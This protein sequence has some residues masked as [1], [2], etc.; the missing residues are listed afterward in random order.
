MKA[1]TIRNFVFICVAALSSVF[2]G[3]GTL[4]DPLSNEIIS[5]TSA[6]GPASSA[7]E[8]VAANNNWEKIITSESYTGKIAFKFK[9]ETA[10]RLRNDS[11]G[12][13]PLSKNLTRSRNVEFISSTGRNLSRVTQLIRENASA[14][15]SRAIPNISEEAL[16]ELKE[17]FAEKGVYYPDWNLTYIISDNDRNSALEIYRQ[18][19]KDDSIEW[20]EPIRKKYLAGVIQTAD[21]S[22]EQNYLKPFSSHSGV[23]ALAGWAAGAFGQ[24]VTIGDYELGWN[25]DHEDI[26]IDIDDVITNMQPGMTQAEIDHGT[27]VIGVVA[28]LHNSIGIN[29][30]APQSNIKLLDA[31]SAGLDFGG[32]WTDESGKTV[33]IQPGDILMIEVQIPGTINT[34]CGGTVEAQLGCLPVESSTYEFNHISSLLAAGYIIIEGAGNGSVDLSQHLD[35]STEAIMVGASLGGTRQKAPWSNC[36]PRVDL[37]AWGNNVVTTGYGDK[38]PS[39]TDP[40]KKYTSVFSGTSSATAIVGGVAAQIQSYVK[41]MLSSAGAAGVDRFY[42]DNS[43][44][45]ELLFASG[46][47]AVYG[48]PQDPNPNCNIGKQPDVAAAIALLEN[49]FIEEFN[50]NSKTAS[51]TQYAAA[52]DIDGDGRSDVVGLDKNFV[53]RIDLSSVASDAPDS[54][55]G[56]GE[57]D[58]TLDFSEYTP[59]GGMYFP[60]V[61]DINSDGFA[62]L[63]IY[64]SIS[65][66]LYIHYT[67]RDMFDN[68]VDHAGGG[69]SRI[70]DY[71][72]DPNWQPY[73]RPMLGNVNVQFVSADGAYQLDLND[74]ED[75]VTIDGNGRLSFS[76]MLGDLDS[77]GLLDEEQLQ[78]APGWAY[79]NVGG[80]YL[81]LK[82]PDS[83]PNPAQTTM[84]KN[85]VSW[86][87]YKSTTLFCTELA[88]LGHDCANDVIYTMINGSFGFKLPTGEYY[89][90]T[91]SITPESS[92]PQPIEGFGGIDCRPI[93]ADY[94]G[95][96]FVDRATY[97]GDSFRVAF[98]ND[99]KLYVAN[100]PD[101]FGSIPAHIYQGGVKYSDIVAIYNALPNKLKPGCEA[102]ANCSIFDAPPPIGPRFAECLK[103]W[104]R[105]PQNCWNE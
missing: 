78:I 25:F 20:V 15:V 56:F 83:S 77:H 12:E 49:G 52:Y 46:S 57:N 60:V 73:M 6:D 8:E 81:K 64:D 90:Y 74:G 98:E 101:S 95:D 2:A 11:G 91:A 38:D 87:Q 10:A 104:A 69:W 44:M 47:E 75:H 43:K 103:N 66:K 36:G 93:P 80:A 100:Y 14:S 62:D 63:G 68:V 27:A 16:D 28:G 37:F 29:G 5:D 7:D 3:C 82:A 42:I 92:Y 55:M 45:R 51:Q 41:N 24:G 59:S 58:L 61:G 23:N 32:S 30:I 105:P 65:G 19:K 4:A 18:L 1:S 79:H 102:G 40:D 85:T 72:D 94:D 35:N 17:S 53:F 26:P 48:G 67:D 33:K 86:A 13:L 70:V 50:F 96:G 99:P 84:F 39:Q 97:C 88:K 89:L 54:F 22:Q 9:T 76:D 21:Y 31:E 71:S 34:T